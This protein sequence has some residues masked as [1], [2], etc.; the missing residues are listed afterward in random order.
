MIR[1]VADPETPDQWRHV[2]T[3][4]A[5]LLRIDACRQYGLIT[6]GPIVNVNRCEALIAGARKRGIRIT[7]DAIDAAVLAIVRELAGPTEIGGES[8]APDQAKNES[9]FESAFESTFG[10]EAPK[11]DRRK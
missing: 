5:A 11:P 7:A 2:A 9:A 4:A 1:T 10:G 6:G 8:A 3:M